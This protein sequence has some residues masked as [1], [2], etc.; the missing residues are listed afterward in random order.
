MKYEGKEKDQIPFHHT[1]QAVLAHIRNLCM[2]LH[3]NIQ[4]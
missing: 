3:S 4:Y 1:I 2:M